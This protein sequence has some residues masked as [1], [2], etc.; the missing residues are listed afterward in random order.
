MAND[1]GENREKEYCVHINMTYHYDLSVSYSVSLFIPFL[2]IF[3]ISNETNEYGHTYTDDNI[4][5]KL[6][7][8]QAVSA[9]QEI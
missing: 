6:G 5:G 2:F 8:G 4:V 1:C 3:C 9:A 7:G